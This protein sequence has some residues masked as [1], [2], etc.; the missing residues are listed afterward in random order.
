MKRNN[1]IIGSVGIVATAALF[2]VSPW[3]SIDSEGTYTQEAFSSLTEKSADDARLWLDRK[4]I[5]HETGE[6]I[7]DKK[8]RQIDAAV[9]QMEKSRAVAFIEQGPDNIGGRTRA[10]QVDV[11]NNNIIWAGG[12][13]GGLFK[14]LNGANLWERVESYE[15]LCSPYISSMTQFTNGTLFVATGSNDEGW[16][17]DGVWYTQDQGATWAVVPG[18]ESFSRVT[19][20]VAP[21][22]G[23]TLWLTTSNG[24]KKWNLGDLALTD[25]TTGN[26][27]CNALAC[28]PNGQ[29][30]V[31]A[32]GSNKT[33][34][35]TDF[36]ATFVD[37]SGSGAGVVPTNA[38]RIEYSVSPTTNSSGNYSIY[39]VRTNANLLG[40]N[41]SHD[42]GNTWS[43]FVGSSGTPS[44]LDIYRNQG[45]YNSIVSVDPQN[46]EKIYI[47]GID[48]WK[49]EQTSNNPPA[50]GFEKLSEWFFAPTSSKYVHADNHEMKWAG[51]KLYI[52]NDGGIGVTF[53]PEVAFF[54]ANR[55]YNVTQFYGIAFDKNGAVMGGAQD[56]GTLYNDHQLSTYKEFTEVSGGDGFQCEI[57]FY[58]PKIMFTCSQYGSG[59]RSSDGGATVEEF[60]PNPIPA[61]YD[62]FGTDG[63]VFHPFHTKLFLAEYY[64][65]NSL[66]SVVFIPDANYPTGTVIQVPSLATGDTIAHTLTSPLYFDD[67]LNYNSSLSVT[68]T[69]IVNELTGQT[70][71]LD[72]Y[73][74]VHL[75]TSGS[76]LVPPLVG[77]S[78][79]VDVETGTDTMVVE[80][81]GSYTHYY[82]QNPATSA[83]YDME[84]DSVLFNVA[85]NR[86]TV[87]DPYQSWYIMYV[88]ANGGELWGTRNA[89]RLSAQDQQW[90]IIAQNIGNLVSTNPNRYEISEI[91]FSRDLN[92][93]YIVSGGSTVHRIDGLGSLYSSTPTFNDD[94]FY[95]VVTGSPTAVAPDATSKVSFNPGGNVQ[96]IGV[97]PSDAD[98]I[99]VVTGFG[100]SSIKRSLNGT[101]ASPSF[102]T[103]GSIAGSNSPAT[104]D[105]IIDRSDDQ[106]LVVGTSSGVFVTEDGGTTWQDGSTGFCGTP[107]YEVRQSWRS[108]DEG[109]FRPGEIYIGTFGRGIW[110][111]T[112]YLSTNEA[113]NGGNNGTTIEEFDTN[114]FPYP[115]PTSASTS[116]SFELA[117]SS[118]VTIQVYNLSGRL[119]KSISKKNMSQGSQVIDIE[120]ADLATGT[121]VVKMFAGKQQATTKF[122]KM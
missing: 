15:L 30:M 89:L 113:Y 70:V 57:S 13:S 109:N 23:T 46:P 61:A 75:G 62:E 8:L 104:Y 40:M 36:G 79:L 116:L 65:L 96:G 71:F 105:V 42:S 14:S 56:N 100:A 94:A 5:D 106:I 60:I 10:I 6:R 3:K 69:S 37:K 81:L 114:L 74:W 80:S 87:Q 103:V 27:G 122:V 91:E 118:D 12:V 16:S 110:S 22:N 29:V 108:W 44:N 48:V 119:V 50:G 43:Q 102:T 28:S 53:N 82:A 90:G 17:G 97:N 32:I 39:A 1:V 85:W 99:V 58:N 51:N 64:D 73:N 47:G 59:L 7:S 88:G 101:S 68:E 76:G 38:P 98:D 78:L 121:Y 92:Q 117:N 77:D 26:G 4:Y 33:Y 86:V 25:V 63:S 45:G 21:K 49:W 11:T 93:L 24:L 18:T 35:S 41:V 54:P 66:D 31:A 83:I 112:S 20:V 115:N 120:G 84:I 9:S 2:A 111:S 19:E 67:T 107:V 52:G 95:H 72:L 55:G 34:V